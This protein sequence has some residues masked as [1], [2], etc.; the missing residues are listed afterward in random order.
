[1]GIARKGLVAAALALLGAGLVAYAGD[2]FGM[3][4]SNKDCGYNAN[5]VFGGGRLFEQATGYC[6]T[7]GKFVHITWPRPGA[8]LPEGGKVVAKPEP[9]AEVWNPATGEV[10]RIYK[11]PGCGGGFMEIRAPAELTHCPKC[12]KDGFKI[13]PR[14]P[15][16][17]ID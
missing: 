2:G 14:A 11:C 12:G 10:R 5:V 9:L 17:A 8:P 6:H 1:V 15:R 7:C 13:D 16:V 3:K 4:C